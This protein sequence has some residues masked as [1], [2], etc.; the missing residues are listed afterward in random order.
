MRNSWDGMIIAS[1]LVVASIVAFGVFLV[2][3]CIGC[4]AARDNA[5]VQA[6]KAQVGDMQTTIAGWAS[7]TSWAIDKINATN[8]MGGGGDS[9]AL[10]LAI[11]ALACAALAYPIGRVIRMRLDRAKG[12][13]PWAVE[14]V[15]E[16]A[17]RM[18]ATVERIRVDDRKS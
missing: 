18:D 12:G 17:R 3:Q 6:V 15:A 11:V 8:T 5:E 16:A 2:V 10:W 1:Y 4:T 9:I 14:E 13:N 7:N